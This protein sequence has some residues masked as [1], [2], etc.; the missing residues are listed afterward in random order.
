MSRLQVQWVPVETWPGE[1]RKPSERK[2]SQFAASWQSTLE[3]LDTE[4][5]AIGA[6]GV[7]IQAY[8]RREDLRLD[9]MPRA[10]IAPSA[11]GVI[12]TFKAKGGDLSFPCDTFDRWN[13]NLRAI[14]L[15]LEALRRIER[16]G[17][18]RRN[19]Q[20]KGWAKLPAAPAPGKMEPKDALV[21]I[22]LHCNGVP[23]NPHY[24]KAAYRVA[25]AKL[26]PDNQ[27][28]GDE[29]QFRIL[30]DAKQALVDAYGWQ[31]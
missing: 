5:S 3:L 24:F 6:R 2:R 13:D 17:V 4:L 8:Y 21:F 14:A 26:H 10:G 1:P 7:V 11:P 20:Y 23:V 29:H 15:A 18:T 31:V 28:T 22:G 12:I 30:G 25:A 19:E 16:Y 9:G 27:Q